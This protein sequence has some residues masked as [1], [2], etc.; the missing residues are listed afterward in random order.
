MLIFLLLSF[1]TQVTPLQYEICFT[2]NLALMHTLQYI[3][4]KT[5]QQFFK[6]IPDAILVTYMCKA[7]SRNSAG[8]A[9]FEVL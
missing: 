1:F 2:K 4:L 8:S 7:D 3:F 6:D 5:P 9:P